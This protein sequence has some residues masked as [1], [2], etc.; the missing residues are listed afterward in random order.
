M[1]IRVKIILLLILWGLMGCEDKYPQVENQGNAPLTVRLS[2]SAGLNVSRATQ[3]PLEERNI[4]N[5]YLFVFDW[6]GNKVFDGYYT[7]GTGV[8]KTIVITDSYILGGT[9]MTIA[10]VANI[11]NEIMSITRTDLAPITTLAEL[12]ALNASMSSLEHPLQRGSLFL[13]SGIKT[14]VSLLNATNTETIDLIRVDAKVKFNIK[15]SKSK[16]PDIKFT[17]T[18]W[19]VHSY[20]KSVKVTSESTLASEFATDPNNYGT[21][22]WYNY[23]QADISI[24]PSSKPATF[25]FYTLESVL[26][27]GTI[28]NS[29]TLAEQYALREKQLKTPTNGAYEYAPDSATYVEFVGDISYTPTGT[30]FKELVANVRYVVHLGGVGLNSDNLD[31]NNFDS[32]RNVN[33]TYNIT[34]K[35]VEDISVE[36][37][38]NNEV[39]P[40][41]EGEVVLARSIKKIDAYNTIFNIDFNTLVVDN[42]LQWGVETPFSIGGKDENVKDYQWMYFRLAAGWNKDEDKVNY[43]NSLR[44]YLGDDE[45]YA[46]KLDADNKSLMDDFVNKTYLEDLKK[47]EDKMFNVDQLVELLKYCKARL[48]ANPNDR[49]LFQKDGAVRFTTY[50]KEYYYSS[51]PNAA[52]SAFEPMLWQKFANVDQRIMN[53][54]TEYRQ[55]TD[56]E[57]SQMNATYS[58]RQQSIQT[59]YNCDASLGGTFSAFGSQ[60]YP[61]SKPNDPDGEEPFDEIN[62]RKDNGRANMQN[63]L[64]NGR[65]NFAGFFNVGVD[66]W[67]KYINLDTWT[68]KGDYDYPQYRSLLLNRDVD[69][70]GIIDA[71]EIQWYLASINQLMDLWIG[72]DSF[73]PTSKLYSYTYWAKKEEHYASSSI[74]SNRSENNPEILWTSEGAS[75]GSLKV[76][77]LSFYKNRDIDKLYYRSLRNLGIKT[78]PSGETD[79]FVEPDKIYTYQ[80]PTSSSDGYVDL[81]RLNS[82]S[83]RNASLAPLPSH[84]LRDVA[85]NNKPARKFIISRKCYGK[86]GSDADKLADV[87]TT[88]GN[89]TWEQING[90]AAGY[91]MLNLPDNWR[92]PNQRELALMYSVLPRNSESWPLAAHFSRTGFCNAWEVSEI[93]PGFMVVKNGNTLSLVNR[94][95]YNP[96]GGVR[97]VKD[98]VQ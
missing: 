65:K 62:F 67:S 83:I 29:G 59:M 27:S 19:R 13:M 2:S 44:T 33:Y 1:N 43:S 20:P 24:S 9:D 38:S 53:I 78:V 61:N 57:S 10:V 72:E 7:F 4:I 96:S 64:F 40:G 87:I 84:E 42:T 52:S 32:Y 76:R 11:E 97:P 50:V 46:E 34:I 54:Y 91:S 86:D 51:N 79:G 41:V 92:L 15:V 14:D 94:N 82:K 47:G 5:A 26:N 73:H 55:S 6:Q 12:K 75:V 71:N 80:L 16:Y 98:V 60:F 21:T 74:V 66:K 30:V 35:G 93:R 37:L 8:D 88:G 3:D 45:V 58:I 69:G 25:S 31:V 81:K 70:D 48:D 90:E 18:Q 56:L 22:G 68:L 28:P 36:V 89:L 85:G 95:N 77:V 39:R 23:E 63:D 17:P 49:V